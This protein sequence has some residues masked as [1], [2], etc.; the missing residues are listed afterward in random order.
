MKIFIGMKQHDD[1]RLVTYA[2]HANIEGI[3]Q[4][5][6]VCVCVVLKHAATY[7]CG[8]TKGHMQCKRL[9]NLNTNPNHAY[10][11]IGIHDPGPRLSTRTT[12][13]VNI[14]TAADKLLQQKWRMSER[15]REN[16]IE[17]SKSSI[18]NI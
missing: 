12:Q 5:V 18:I 1:L 13:I 8:H 9:G 16:E 2:L 6:C 4:H 10:A 17:R 7:K 14:A 11:G 15:K 3:D